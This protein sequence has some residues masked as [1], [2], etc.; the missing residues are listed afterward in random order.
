MTRSTHTAGNIYGITSANG[1]L[2]YCVGN[3]TIQSL[4]LSDE[5]VSDIESGKLKNNAYISYA[6]DRLYHTSSNGSAIIC[7]NIYGKVIWEFRTEKLQRPR[8]IAVDRKGRI[9]V[10]GEASNNVIQISPDGKQFTEL[11][12][13]SHEIC[14]PSA[15]CCDRKNDIIVI[16]NKNGCLFVYK[17]QDDNTDIDTGKS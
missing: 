15:I 11:L 5:S 16:C 6:E 12:T 4:N 7:C 8:G 1:A 10:V 9:Y 2:I 13:K 17:I 3:Q 14:K